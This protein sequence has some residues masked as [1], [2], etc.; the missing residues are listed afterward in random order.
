M[1]VFHPIRTVRVFVLISRPI[2]TLTSLRA[3]PY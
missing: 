3:I 1:M 2:L